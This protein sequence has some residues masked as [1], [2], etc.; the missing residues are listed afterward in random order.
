MS[1]KMSMH[2]R[3]WGRHIT[4]LL[5][6]AAV[7][8]PALSQTY[9]AESGKLSGTDISR[10][11][12]GYSGAGYVT[13]FDA[14]GDKVTLEIE[15][16]EGVYNLYVRYAS[17][18]GDKL[19]FINVNGE[20]LGSVLFTQSSGFSENKVGKVFLGHGIN[21]LEIAKDWGY[22][23]VDYIRI[24]EASASPT[25]NFPTT[26][27]TPSPSVEADSLYSLLTELYGNA[28][29][30]GQYGG[31][32]EFDYIRNVSDKVP[33]IR[34]FDFMDYS[35]SRVERGATSTET[36][37]AIAWSTEQG[38]VTFSWHWNAP[39]DLIDEPGKEWWRGFYTEATTFDVARAMTDESSEEYALIIRD[40]DAIAAQLKELSDANVPVLWR[41]LHE[42][43]G[44]W[45]W[46]G[47]KGPEACKWLW[48]I[49]FE[50][51]VQ[52]HALDNLIW[53]WTSTG[54]SDALEWYPGDEFVDI[55]GADIYLS[56]GS[57][58]TN[59]I[60]FDNIAALYEGRKMIALAENGP[61]PHPEKLFLQRVGWSWFC[62]WSGDFITDGLTNTTSHIQQVYG[63][64]YVITL[65]EIGDIQEILSALELKRSQGPATPVTSIEDPRSPVF[66]NPINQKLQLYD[67]GPP[68]RIAVYDLQGTLAFPIVESEDDQYVEFD[69]SGKAAGMYILKIVTRTGV[70]TFRVVSYNNR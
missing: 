62:T 16:V 37:N 40:I 57:Y 24:E 70:K 60:T 58:G 48:R 17:P 23:D 53:V 11:M 49:L 28:I 36:E 64:E 34:G 69:F 33:V 18:F 8:F 7:V 55:I 2:I 13:G 6:L 30:S 22:F 1:L 12:A 19:N 26:P 10:Q 66:K 63:H 46:W 38:I 27:V 65:D 32:A 52:Y 50:R 56:P 21:T 59:F 61:I 39:K 41:P 29:L 14:V 4:I 47:A 54:N 31:P 35:P 43:E 67:L 68:A 51:L 42:A 15:A 9:E 3:L 44:R 25:A 20:D 5:L 45:F